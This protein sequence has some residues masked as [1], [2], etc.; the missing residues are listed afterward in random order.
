M[1]IVLYL[2]GQFDLNVLYLIGQFGL[3]VL[4]LIGQFGLERRL[5]IAIIDR[6]F[7]LKYKKSVS[8]FFR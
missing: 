3:N 8:D 7:L 6:T 1:C 5:L 4:Y 2:I